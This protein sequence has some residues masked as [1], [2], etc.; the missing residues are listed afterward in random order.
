MTLTTMH[1]LL[2]RK[3][4]L[5][6]SNTILIC[7]EI[8]KP[9]WAYGI[10]R[11]GTA[12][13]SNIEILERFQSNVLRVIVEA[14]RYVPNTV[15]R[16]DL[17]TPTV[18][19]EIRHYSFQCTPKRPSSEPHGANRQLAI[20]KALAKRSAYQILNVIVLFVVWSLRFSL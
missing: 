8:L 7:K 1:W 14:P 10:Q 20:A 6:T 4:K 13:T 2:G 3:S 16:R 5:S 18:K 9:M 19:E 12:S 11:W 17:Q 15:I